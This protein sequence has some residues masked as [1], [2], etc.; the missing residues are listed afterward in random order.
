[1]AVLSTLRRY[2]VVVRAGGLTA[3]L[4]VSCALVLTPG[5]RAATLA[6]AHLGSALSAPEPANIGGAAPSSVT[7]SWQRCLRYATLVRSDGASDAWPLDESTT[8]TAAADS[9]G[10]AKGNYAGA[11]ASVTGAL[12]GEEDP[13]AGFDGKTSALSV[14]GAPD[15]S[16]ADPYTLELW[17]RPQTVDSTYRFL[18]AREQTNASGRQGTGIWLS[19]AGLGFERWTN[20]VVANVHYAAGL[21]LGE[22]SQ[23]TATYDGQT[24]RLYVDGAQVGSR[25]RARRSR[26]S[27]GRPSSAPVPAAGPVSSRAR[28]IKSPR[29]R[30]R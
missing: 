24:M 14:T 30:V 3:L 20:G 5:S 4:C 11:R 12:A 29:I 21:P 10:A 6:P 19:S 1:L 16:G 7:Y 27:R 26:P 8:T 9:I 28:S 15:Y 17:V 2:K 18:L 22:W 25:E 23:V 13:A